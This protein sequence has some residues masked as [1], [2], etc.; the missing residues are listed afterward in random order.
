MIY[1]TTITLNLEEPFDLPVDDCLELL[2][3]TYNGQSVGST[4]SV[5]E[6]NEQSII[7]A[8]D[9]YDDIVDFIKVAKK[10][11]PTLTYTDIEE[12]WD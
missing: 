10:D 5:G 3:E 12:V 9:Q 11:F 8:F 4:I 1:E 2:A 7:Y 6:V